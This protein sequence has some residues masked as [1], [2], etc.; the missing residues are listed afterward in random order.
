LLDDESG[1]FELDA[2]GSFVVAEDVA[3]SL[4]GEVGEGHGSF[5]EQEV[6]IGEGLLEGGGEMGQ[7][8]A[9]GE[10]V[11]AENV[12]EGDGAVDGA[13]GGDHVDDLLLLRCEFGFGHEK[14]IWPTR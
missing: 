10:D 14:L 1:G 13:A 6:A 7:V 4:V 11:L 8:A 5:A 9:P 3:E 2:G 12:G